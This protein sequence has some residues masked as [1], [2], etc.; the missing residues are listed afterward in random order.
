MCLND[1]CK[2]HLKV[3]LILSVLQDNWKIAIIFYL[4][5]VSQ[6]RGDIQLYL[7][8]SRS[9][10][11]WLWAN[12]TIKF[13]LIFS[14]QKLFNKHLTSTFHLPPFHL[15][16]VLIPKCPEDERE[17]LYFWLL[18]LESLFFYFPCITFRVSRGQVTVSWEDNITVCK[19]HGSSKKQLKLKSQHPCFSTSAFL[20]AWFFL[21]LMVFED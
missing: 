16:I 6:R 5:G 14:Y 9:K 7:D 11:K 13:R 20:I 15:S 18:F 21:L 4:S 17:W 3:W 8:T 12:F 1:K 19:R 10:L 2:E